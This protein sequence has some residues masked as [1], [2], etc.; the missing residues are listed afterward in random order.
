MGIT[1]KN[2]NNLCPVLVLLARTDCYLPGASEARRIF[3]RS[4][5]V[6]PTPLEA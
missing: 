3:E 5:T 4:L 6:V 2:Q 1:R